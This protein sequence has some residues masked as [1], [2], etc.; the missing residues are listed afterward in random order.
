MRGTRSWMDILATTTSHNTRSCAQT[1]ILYTLRA[2]CVG[3]MPYGLCY[4]PATFERLVMY[5]FTDL[6]FKSW[7]IFIDEFSTQYSIS[8]HLECARDT[9][10]RCKMMQLALNPVKT[11][12]GVQKGVYWVMR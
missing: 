4:A 3:G 11:F 8:Q 12:L 10:F 6:F 9:F 7:T 5:I 1:N 2:F